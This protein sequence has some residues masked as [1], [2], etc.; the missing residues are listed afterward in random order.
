MDDIV[1][2]RL[3]E[4]RDEAI[5]EA[6]GGFVVE[7]RRRLPGASIDGWVASVEIPANRHKLAER[8][9]VLEEQLLEA[10]ARMAAIEGRKS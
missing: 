7:G 8:L 5:A 6:A 9:R 3:G 4:A 2:E 10:T 1:G